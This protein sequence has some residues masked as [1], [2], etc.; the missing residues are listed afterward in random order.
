MAK[1]PTRSPTD[2]DLPIGRLSAMGL[3]LEDIADGDEVAI[4]QLIELA[5]DRGRPAS[6]Y[7]C[8][9]PLATELRV[10]PA[11]PVTVKIC[12]GNCQRWG[13]RDVI[14]HVVDRLAAA[15][16]SLAIVP[17]QCLDR[18]DLAP[19]C[20]LHGAHGQLVIAPASQ[21]KLDEALDALK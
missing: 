11:A 3:E 19:A 18:C 6:H 10:G 21:A 7:L 9:I 1:L 15:P 20:E 4:D 2:E 14:D 12:A 5:E 8:A 13:A 16:G 17:V